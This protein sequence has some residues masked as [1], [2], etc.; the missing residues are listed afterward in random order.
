MWSLLIHLTRV[1]ILVAQ[2]VA[3][4]FDDDHLHT[5]ADA[6]GRDVVGAGV[7]GSDDLA[8]DAALAESWTDDDAVLTLQLFSH[9]LIC[10]IF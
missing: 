10:E 7:V 5:Q 3:G 8:L 4:E 1:G 9:V 6:E 2:Y